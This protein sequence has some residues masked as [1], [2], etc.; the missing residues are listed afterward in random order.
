MYTCSIL[1]RETSH[2]DLSRCDSG[3]LQSQ[4]GQ[5]VDDNISR[6]RGV[7][8]GHELAASVGGEA[9]INAQRLREEASLL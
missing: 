6:H 8:G 4:A 3:G 1:L 5:W 2:C 9:S 7:R